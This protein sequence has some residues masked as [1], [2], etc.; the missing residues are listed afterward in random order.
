MNGYSGRRLVFDTNPILLFLDGK[1]D[2]LPSGDRF[3]S[4]HLKLPDAIIAA[5]TVILEAALVTND[6]ALLNLN[7]NGLTALAVT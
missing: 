3:G 1:A 7:W 5:T 4:P 6:A 2:S